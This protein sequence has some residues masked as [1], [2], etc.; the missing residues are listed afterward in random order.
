MAVSR[1]DYKRGKEVLWARE[2]GDS[3]AGAPDRS[4]PA[5]SVLLVGGE[6]EDLVTLFGEFRIDVR[7]VVR[8]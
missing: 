3:P 5:A 8:A 4:K 2:S 6:L 1:G 7:A